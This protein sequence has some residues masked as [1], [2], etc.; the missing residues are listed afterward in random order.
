[1]VDIGTMMLS[2]KPNDIRKVLE[3]PM[4]QAIDAEELGK[5]FRF[6]IE[7]K[8]MD[9]F[10]EMTAKRSDIKP[11]TA[12]LAEKQDVAGLLKMLGV[13]N[14][15]NPSYMG[16]P[17]ETLSS[18]RDILQRALRGESFEG[19]V[20]W[21]DT[22]KVA[23]T[24]ERMERATFKTYDHK[25]G[26]KFTTAELAESKAKFIKRSGGNTQ[27]YLAMQV[28]EE[29]GELL[30][31][32]LKSLG[33]PASHKSF[34]LIEAQ[35]RAL[36]V[37]R[38]GADTIIK[39][40]DSAYFGMTNRAAADAAAKKAGIAT[41][42]RMNIDD[43]VLELN[44]KIMQA[45]STS[46]FNVSLRAAAK[47]SDANLENLKNYRTA[48]ALEQDA[49]S[50]GAQIIALTTKNKE[51]AALSNVVAT[52]QKRRLYDEIAASTYNDPRFR[53]LNK[54]L[55]LNEKDLRKAAKAQNMVSFYGAGEK[56]GAMGVEG[57]LA[58]ALG[59]DSGTL[60]VKAS[61]RDAVLDAI[62]A[63]LARY[64]RFDTELANELRALRADVRDVFNKGLTPGQEMLE[65][66]Y[67]LDPATRDFVEKMSR[68][69]SKVVTPDDFKYIA[70][71]MSEKLGEQVPI[72]KKF[73][74]FTG[75]L[76]EDFLTHAKP[77]NSAMD[78]KRI[79]EIALVGSEKGGYKVRPVWL[80]RQLGIDPN[81]PV[82]KQF[83]E[84]FSFWAPDGTL[85]KLIYGAPSPKTRRTGFKYAKIEILGGAKELHSAELLYANKLQKS[86]TNVPWVNFD[87][88]VIEQNFTQSFE[89]KIRYKDKNGNWVTN[90]IQVQQKTEATPW[91]VLTN[92]TGKINDIADITKARTAYGV[93]ANHSNDAVIVKKFHLWG[94]KNGVAT[95]TIH[96][97]FFAN[98]AQML[99][100][101]EALRGIYG[102]VLSSNV[103]KD[104]L[105]E[106]LKRGLPKELY[107]KYLNEAIDSG[108]IPV[109]GRS[110]IGGKVI[111][112]KDILKMKDIMED[113][114][115]E[116]RSD[117]GWYGVG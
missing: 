57:K 51:L 26:R 92:Q 14:K 13:N 42:A 3:H 33:L 36:K 72:L 18:Q 7:L 39:D 52:N 80:A 96:D 113:V 79:A 88:K 35:K 75:R 23:L 85:S 56:T 29:F 67:F 99:Q 82:S 47:Y 74:N 31:E 103:I 109:P 11:T 84:K 71:I 98:A 108:L 117:R 64:E 37:S 102:E 104:T 8:K 9:D 116:F 69:Y 24:K 110:V 17:A 59:K 63:R 55:G 81:K 34:A 65:Q 30:E 46:D 4:V 20:S 101:R 100:A 105:D 114:E 68:Q 89:E 28:V 48:L 43:L 5:F 86:W 62:S 15:G 49:S 83:L 73:T 107:T 1:M 77:K 54:R 60:V 53:E 16:T 45:V 87:K 12:L 94:K 25:T 41:A 44:D 95:S 50:S 97:A 91:E 66:L 19:S 10:L 111:T 93:N 6:A 115:T 32:Q 76:A 112:E 38:F 27:R 21:L 2:K 40:A 61:E 70:S 78:W 58:K 106:M 22:S 90:I